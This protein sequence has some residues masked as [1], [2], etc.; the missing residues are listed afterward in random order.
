VTG[1][2][3]DVSV[4]E[5]LPEDVG[6]SDGVTLGVSLDVDDVDDVLLGVGVAVGLL[7]VGGRLLSVGEGA[8]DVVPATG[9]GGGRT[10]M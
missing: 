1:A 10:R 7:E 9:A 8:G 3:S 5:G 2:L 6:V 4:E